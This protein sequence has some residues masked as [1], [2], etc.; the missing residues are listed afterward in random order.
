MQ[1][2]ATKVRPPQPRLKKAIELVAKGSGKA[3]AL[4]QAGFSEA[5]ARSPGKALT[6]PTAIAYMEK[7]G[8]GD[9]MIS[10]AIKRNLNAKR[11]SS[12]TF[13]NTPLSID[14]VRKLFE[15]QEIKIISIHDKQDKD[16]TDIIVDFWADVHDP[17]CRVLD[18]LLKAKGA[19]TDTADNTPGGSLLSLRAAMDQAG[20]DVV[21]I[22]KH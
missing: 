6:T 16:G 8:I 21:V 10:A 15:E 13:Y 4:R 1:T 14:E 19:Y 17:Q 9:E 5:V 22:H 7:L 2:K 11:P 20:L 12:R 3:S 18:M